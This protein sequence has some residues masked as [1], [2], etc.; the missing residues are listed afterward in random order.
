[1]NVPTP[2]PRLSIG[3]AKKKGGWVC[4]QK[5]PA[6]VAVGRKKKVYD[7]VFDKGHALGGWATWGC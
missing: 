6:V 5:R 2:D 1:M 4:M 3:T 7:D